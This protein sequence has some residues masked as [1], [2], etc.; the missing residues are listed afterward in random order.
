V[1]VVL[2]PGLVCFAV[3][4]FGA[5]SAGSRLT[6]AIRSGLLPL[7]AGLVT[8]SAFVLA[9]TIDTNWRLGLMT[10]SF[11]LILLRTQVHP[12][13]LIAAGGLAGGAGL[14]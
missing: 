8:A 3:I 5:R 4:R 6:R 7:S 12:L 2:P 13:W 14:L 1:A 11:A 9:M 10:A